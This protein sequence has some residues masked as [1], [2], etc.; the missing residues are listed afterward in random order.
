MDGT[1]WE[2]L[3]AASGFAALLAGAAAV[4]FERGPVN[5]ND[6]PATIA[7]YFADN[8]AALRA[9]G[10]LFLVGGGIFLWFLGSLRSFL[11]R[12]EGGTGRLATVALA[13][14]VASTVVTVV[15]LTFQVGLAAASGG[16]GQP[17]LV[18]V[19]DALF[20]AANVPL[21]VMLVAV[22][23]VSLR[24]GA[25]PA[26]LGWLS[27]AA[28]A[29]QLAPSLG[30]VLDGGPLA[31]DGWLAAY[32]PYPLYVVWLACATAVML[33]RIGRQAPAPAVPST[34]GELVDRVRQH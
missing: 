25:L 10:L 11:A 34:P 28:A 18:A 26:W 23:L 5:A 7:A 13:A 9:Q 24:T 14:G 32:L 6:P 20:T 1:R 17:A 4:V 27:V 8:Q 21:A 29:A 30:I 16:T 15:A 31:F 19:M 12:A 3:G 2:R 22:A 33:R